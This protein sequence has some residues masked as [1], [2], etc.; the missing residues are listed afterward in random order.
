MS[1]K[2]PIRL[3]VAH[4]F[5]EDEDYA[6]VFEYLESRDNFFYQ[7][8]SNPTGRPDVGG[9]ERLKEELLNQIKP[10]EI[11]VLPVGIYR[12]HTNLLNY[13]MDAAQACNIPILGIKE[14]GAESADP[15]MVAESAAEIVEWNDRAITEAIRRVARNEGNEAWEVIEFTLE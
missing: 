6:R 15:P 5:E 2:D 1:E 9:Q 3:F 11:L 7:N 8:Y 12:K 14:F 4:A 10:T 13:Q